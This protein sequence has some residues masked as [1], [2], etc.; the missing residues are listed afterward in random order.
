MS[1]KIS[2]DIE[3]LTQEDFTKLKLINLKKWLKTV[4]R[5]EVNKEFEINFRLM[6][7]NNEEIIHS[8]YQDYITTLGEIMKELGETNSKKNVI[9]DFIY[10]GNK[11]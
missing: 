11:I 6:L 9:F 1:E 10:N 3:D 4:M 5:Q 2:V 7:E 8:L